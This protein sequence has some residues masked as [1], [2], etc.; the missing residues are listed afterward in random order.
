MLGNAKLSQRCCNTHKHMSIITLTNS[1][2]DPCLTWSRAAGFG[3]QGACRETSTTAG[4]ATCAIKRCCARRCFVFAVTHAFRQVF[5]QSL[6]PVQSAEAAAY[7]SDH[8]LA[9]RR[10][11]YEP[12]NSA[13]VL[14]DLLHLGGLVSRALDFL[15]RGQVVVVAQALIVIVDA[16][17]ELDHA[18][19]A[20]GELRGL[21]QVEA[22][23]EQGSVEK[24]PDQVLYGF[25]LSRF[26][27]P[28]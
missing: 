12:L 27:N 6:P 4:P 1:K 2:Q 26:V 3:L 18:V 22:G 21:I 24:E 16:E 23:G 20:A 19:D 15:K 11:R 10:L 17:A 25:V 13:N 9:Y 7:P 8:A 14:V 5:H 28:F